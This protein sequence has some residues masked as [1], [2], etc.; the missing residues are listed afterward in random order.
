MRGGKRTKTVEN[1]RQ[2]CVLEGFEHKALAICRH[3]AGARPRSRY[4]DFM[5]MLNGELLDSGYKDAAAVICGSH[6]RGHLRELV[7]R[8]MLDRHRGQ[9]K[10]EKAIIES[11]SHERI[12]RTLRKNDATIEARPAEGL[13]VDVLFAPT[14]G[15]IAAVAARRAGVVGGG[16]TW[17][18]TSGSGGRFG[19]ET[20][21]YDPGGVRACA[22]RRM[23]P[24]A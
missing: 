20:A 3:S 7:V 21:F 14:T 9:R 22:T 16:R 17:R 12:R 5:E 8:S 13:D 19:S 24:R 18:T 6:L 11:I 1:I 4:A 15:P 23:Q 10:T 2:R